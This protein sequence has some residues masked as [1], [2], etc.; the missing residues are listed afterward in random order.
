MQ[1]GRKAKN[2]NRQ[3]K[4]ADLG[5]S[6]TLALVNVSTNYDANCVFIL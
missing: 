3:R 1:R 2:G 4:N 5:S 6:A